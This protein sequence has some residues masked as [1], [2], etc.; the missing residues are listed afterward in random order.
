MGPVLTS[1]PEEFQ[2]I[3][4]RVRE[5]QDIEITPREELKGGRTGA[6]LFLVS[7]KPA[8]SKKISHLI[9]KLDHLSQKTKSDESKRH[10]L[11]L[12]QAPTAFAK[13]HMAEIAYE[14]THE[15]CIAIFYSIAGQFSKSGL[16]REKH[17]ERAGEIFRNL[18]T[19]YELD[20]V[21]KELEQS[22]ST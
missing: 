10:H 13:G 15:G 17:L 2:H 8:G 20:R 7:V 5:M 18:G 4:L 9:L 14:L 21:K 19:A 12:S 1:F 3:L 6:R 22:R 16:S 11:A